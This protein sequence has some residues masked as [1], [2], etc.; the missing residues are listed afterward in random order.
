MANV[1]GI[2]HARIELKV[3]SKLINECLQIPGAPIR[4]PATMQLKVLVAMLTK[5][6][7]KRSRIE[8]LLDDKKMS[9]TE[10]AA[11]LTE[12]IGEE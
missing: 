1:K 5:H 4:L 10:K 6:A 9:T 8:Q 12:I 2:R 11:R 7:A 3:L